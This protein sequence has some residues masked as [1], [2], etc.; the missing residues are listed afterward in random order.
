MDFFQ[1]ARERYSVRSFMNTP[2]EKE[3]LD[4]ILEA[5]RIAPTA[6]NNQPQRIKVITGADLLKVDEF[7]P[8]RYG[9]P[10]V[11]LVCYDRNVCAPAPAFESGGTGQVDV[12]IVSTH[13]M[14]AAQCLGLGTLWAMHFDPVKASEVFN[15]PAAIV[16]MTVLDI[17]YP[18]KDA[19]PSEMHSDR[20]SIQNILL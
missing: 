20:V 19:V 7:T 2:V 16:P 12:G 13:L 5:G 18:S 17:G 1:L 6:R 8:C 11:L 9:A 10:L 15:L 4:Q 3:K 14:F